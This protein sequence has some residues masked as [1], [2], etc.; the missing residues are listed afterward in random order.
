M[1]KIILLLFPITTLF[2]QLPSGCWQSISAGGDKTMAIGNNGKIWGWGDNGSGALGLGSVSG[3]Q[4]NPIQSAALGTF[5]QVASGGNSFTIALKSDGTLWATGLNLYGFLG[6]GNYTNQSSFVQIGVANNW[7]TISAGGAHV[8]ALKTDGTLWA[9]G[10]NGDGQLGNGSTV[11][12]NIPVQI[13]SDTNW[14]S[15]AAGGYYFSMAIKTDGSLW[16]WGN[17]SYNQMGN[18]TVTQP[19]T[20]PTQLGVATDWDKI[21]AG[22]YHA[23]AIKNNGTLWGWGDNS[24][25]GIGIGN[26]TPVSNP[27]QIGIDANWQKISASSFASYAIKNNGT[28]WAWGYNSNGQLGDGTT[29]QKTIPSQIGLDTDWQ[30]VSGSMGYYYASALKNDGSLWSWGINNFGVLGDGTSTEKRVPTAITCPSALSVDQFKDQS[31]AV[32][33]NPVNDVLY[34]NNA[35]TISEIK[36]ITIFDLTG[37]CITNFNIFDKNKIELN[38]PSTVTSGMYVLKIIT[39]SGA[40]TL[41]FIKK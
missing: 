5:T 35:N 8:L 31:F 6:I 2:A 16:V 21:A 12:S 39:T 11:T 38:M 28:L 41:K 4:L 40:T 14:K 24:A 30:I 26:T 36:N 32:Y 17:D 9:W 1:K 13:G 7:K 19:Y 37:K 23:L 22:Q 20:V 27:I 25:G 18:G 15:V 3:N 29:V 10:L 33:P 34:I